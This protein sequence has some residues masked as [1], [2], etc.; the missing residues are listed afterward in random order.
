MMGGYKGF[1]G[2]D[3]TSARDEVELITLTD[4]D[5]FNN[6]SYWCQRSLSSS[7]ESFDGATI[8]LIDTFNYN[9]GHEGHSDFS[10]A[11]NSLV[12][13]RVLVCGGADTEYR[14]TNLCR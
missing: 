9:E 5:M 14:I 2:E 6:K 11:H 4:A 13:E 10:S 12:F 1:E 3:G 8:D 7:E